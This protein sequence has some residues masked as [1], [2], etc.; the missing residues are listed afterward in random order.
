MTDME[1][2]EVLTKLSRVE[3]LLAS[4]RSKVRFDYDNRTLQPIEIAKLCVTMST[5][6][7]DIS[8]VAINSIKA[9]GK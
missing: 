4:T 7:I 3:A 1:M 8:E 9:Q 5:M 6:L 2:Y